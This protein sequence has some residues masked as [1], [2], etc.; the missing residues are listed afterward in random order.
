MKKLIP[1]FFVV[2]VLVLAVPGCGGS[3][4]PPTDASLEDTWTRPAD[5]M[6]MVYVPEGEFEMGIVPQVKSVHSVALDGFWLDR[7]EVT[8]R[9]YR[10]CVEAEACNP[11]ERSDS[12]SGDAY[13][14]ESAY[15]DYPILWVNWH[16]AVAYCEWAGA[17]LPT[18]A[19]WEYAARGPAG[20]AYPWGNEFDGTRL[21][22]C[23][24]NC[25]ASGG[26]D[27]TADDGYAET[28]PV[29][30]FPS[31][32]S[33]CGALDLAGN[34]YEWMADRYGEYPSEHQV[35]PQGPPSGGSRV[36]RGGSW[37]DKSLAVHSAFRG[38]LDPDRIWY[39]L[40]F[41]CVRD[42]E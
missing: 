42:S 14:G 20:R 33:W 12:F 27:T 8:N 31:G 29:G 40:G 35:N 22:Y 16:Q 7:T 26:A 30:S 28:A 1:L 32:A 4:T 21:N 2:V 38:Q 39:A 18:E 15:D 3:K 34:V 19:E 25:E 24:A 6:V 9:Q 17:R 37:E 11:P 5:E 13:Y 23:D 10:R 41:R 36:L